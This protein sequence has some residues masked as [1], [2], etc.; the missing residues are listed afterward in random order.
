M[1]QFTISKVV[2]G[3]SYKDHCMRVASQVVE[4]CKAQDFSKFGNHWK[5]PKYSTTDIALENISDI[6][7]R[8]ICGGSFLGF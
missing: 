5:I 6:F 3:I 8:N 7:E 1:V 2:H 4:Q